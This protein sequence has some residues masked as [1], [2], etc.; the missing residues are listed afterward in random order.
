MTKKLLLIIPVSLLLTIPLKGS[1]EDKDS[2]C[3]SPHFRNIYVHQRAFIADSVGIGTMEPS[4][5]LDIEG[6][7]QAHAFDTGPIVFRKDGKKLWRMFEDE[8]GLYLENLATE[9]VSRIFLE[10]D[11]EALKSALKE[12]LRREILAELRESD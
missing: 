7:V 11:V 12:E 9:K 5:E 1:A 3:P 4:H 2:T 8:K 6:T 10:E